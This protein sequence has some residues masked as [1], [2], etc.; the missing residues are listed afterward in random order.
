MRECLD[1]EGYL[2]VSDKQVIRYLK[3]CDWH[4]E[5][6]IQS[7]QMCEEI[8]FELNLYSPNVSNF[9]ALEAQKCVIYEGCFDLLGR[10]VIFI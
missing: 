7:I 8:R 5:K 1:A 6:A 3:Y 9:E 2:Y 4:F 10:P